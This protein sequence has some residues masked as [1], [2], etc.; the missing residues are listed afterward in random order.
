VNV[1]ANLADM[2]SLSLSPDGEYV[3]FLSPLNGRQHLVVRKITLLEGERPAVFSPPENA[4]ITR[5]EWVN[6]ERLILSAMATREVRTK[7]GRRAVR[8]QRLIAINRDGSDAKL[9]LNRGANTGGYYLNS[10]PILQ[11]IDREN[12][13]ALFP[14]S[15]RPE[16]DV[17]QLNVNTGL[18]K[19]V[20]RSVNNLTSYVPD[21]TGQVRI[22]RTYNDRT[23]VA[24]YLR[25]DKSDDSYRTLQQADIIHQGIFKVLG[26]S[27]DGQQLYVAD[28]SKQSDRAGI[29]TYDLDRDMLGPR[30]V[31]DARYPIDDAVMKRGAVVAFSWVDDLPQRRWLNPA[32]QELQE[33]LDKAVPGSREVIIDSSEDGA[34]SLVASYSMAEPTVYRVFFRD[35]KKLVFFGDSFPGL[36]SA[37]VA[38]RRPVSFKARDGLEIPAYLTLPVGRGDKNLP[39]IVMPHGGPQS[40][41]DGDYDPLSQFLANRGYGVIQPNFRGST[42][43]GNAFRQAGYR[44]WGGLMQD[45]VTDAAQ[46]VVAQG[47]AD[48]SRMCIL[49]WSYGGY[50]ALMGAI[51]TPDLFKCAVA[52]APV[53]NMDRLYDDLRNHR[54]ANYSRDRIFGDADGFDPVNSPVHRAAEIKIPVL[55]IH[56]DLDVQADVEHSRDMAKVL[57]KAGKDVEYIEIEDMDHSPA[58]RDDMVRILTAWEQFLKAQI[59][60]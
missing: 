13:L 56:G 20:R 28:A 51:K 45:D 8:F 48:P 34:I 43:Y 16:P 39:F 37:E 29:H 6:E 31:E 17:V 25:R 10:T 24:T 57:K 26:F 27:T 4:E 7:N 30:I 59:G 44:Q 40:R 12:V 36:P 50:A 19:L 22:A 42:G 58:N 2:R 3:A 49:G 5:I 46:W 9:L 47:Y 52:T 32:T 41:D 55:L 23:G 14:T 54:A 21:P 11:F 60:N 53:A 1:F 33:R 38:Q 15:G 18:F 35:S